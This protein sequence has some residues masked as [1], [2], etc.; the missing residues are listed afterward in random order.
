MT[1]IWAATGKTP[2]PFLFGQ[3]NGEQNETL[4]LREKLPRQRMA[5]G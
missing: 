4:T 2:S 1:A 5:S 3:W